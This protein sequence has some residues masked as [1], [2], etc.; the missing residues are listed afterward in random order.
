MAYCVHCGV[1][2]GPGEKSCPLCQTPVYDP[3]EPNA[4]D[5]PKAFLVRTPEQ[6]LKRSKRFLFSLSAVLLLSP[7]LLCMV[8]D[9]L[10]HGVI[11]WSG[12]AA[13]ALLMLFVSITAPLLAKKYQ[14]F[15]AIAASFVS[16]IGFLFLVERLSGSGPWFFTV[17]LPAL[18]LAVGLV[19]VI[20]GLYQGR[21]LNKLTLIAAIL[22]AAGI[23]CLGIDWLCAVAANA[24]GGFAWSPYVLAPCLFLSVSLFVIN[25]NRTVR[26][27]LRRRVHF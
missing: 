4:P 20:I 24:E 12:Y 21:L 8:I 6:E 18:V 14:E 17:A 22:A 19:M 16:L 15:V 9:L 7:A 10:T 26:E 27:E 13:G 25:G 1:K 2:L 23:E 5:A 11:S 3:A